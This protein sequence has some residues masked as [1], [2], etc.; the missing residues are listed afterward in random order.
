MARDQVQ[1]TFKVFNEEF[2]KAMSEMREST[3]RLN[4]EFRLQKEQLRLTG[5]ESEK[6]RAEVGY[7]NERY[8]QAQERVK[9]TEQQLAKAKE[10]FGENSKEVK[11]LE[12]Q[13]MNAR[14]E[15]QKFANQL[16]I[17]NKE[18]KIAESRALKYSESLIK[19]GDGLQ[20]AGKKIKDTGKSMTTKITLPIIGLGAAAVKSSIDFESAFAGVRK[21]VDATEEQLKQL[22]TG[23]RNMSKEIPASATAIASVA[24]AAGQLGIETDNILGFSRAMIDLGESTNLSAEEAASALAQ[25]ANI[26]GMSQKDFDRLGSTI[27]ELGNNLATTEADIV[28]MGQRLAGAGAQIGLTEAQIMSFAAALSSVG[29]EAEAGGSAF[30]KV[31]IEMQLATETNSKKLKDFAKVAGMSAKDFKKAFQRDAASAIIAFIKGLSKAEDRGTS[32]IKVLDDMGIKEVRLRDALLR[33]TEASDV[34]TSSIELGSKAWEENTALA[35][36]AAQRYET[37]E[38]RLQIMKNQYIDIGRQLGDK[39]MPVLEKGLDMAQEWVNKLGNLSDAQ[40]E[41]IIKIGLAVAAIGPLLQ[42]TGNAITVVGGFSK[43]IGT[44]SGAIGTMITGA[45]ASTPAIAKLSSVLGALSSPAG[46][47]AA[48]IGLTVGGVAYAMWKSEE[49]TRAAGKAGE[50]FIQSLSTWHDRV[51][52]AKSALEGFNMETII[53]SEKMSELENGIRQ[54]QENIIGI[55]EL[56]AAES[57]AYTE[58]ERKQIEEL[59]GLIAEYTQQKIEA[60]EQQAKVVAAMATQERDITLE[61]A[62]ELIKGAEDARAQLLAIAEVRY[63]EQIAQAIKLYGEQGELDKARYDEMVA[64]AEREYK[65]E[66]ENANKIHGDTLRIIQQKYLDSNTEAKK[67][68]EDVVRINNELARL[69]DEKN[70]KLIDTTNMTRA[71]MQEAARHNFLVE[72]E[73]SNE[74][75]VLL[76]EL[77]DAYRGAE[78][79]NADAWLG[80]A[81]EAELYGG[82]IDTKTKETARGF[83][84]SFQHLPKKSKETMAN[85]MQGMMSEMER[86]EPSLFK[87]ARNIANGILNSLRKAFD[88]R[89]PSRE[90]AKI[91]RQVFEGADKPFA[92]AQKEMSD[93]TKKIADKIMGEMAKVTFEPRFN[94][95]DASMNLTRP[96]L[97]PISQVEAIGMDNIIIKLSD[98]VVPVY[99]E[100]KEIARATAPYMDTELNYIATQRRR[101]R[102]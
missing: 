39:L 78:E 80:M 58:E 13:L 6:L 73:Y 83:I 17:A 74:R 46:L 92:D 7:L 49:A 29:I 75:K 67:Y 10:I 41:N 55:A 93:K 45:E 24:E 26:T 40:M 81:M 51:N 19:I 27:V 43:A 22:E 32:A 48:A 66:I 25:F 50:S 68:L 14:I 100:G 3:T 21:T 11:K 77:A 72:Q 15:E 54:A 35:K 2:K 98:L 86:K 71:E 8:K 9:A 62:Q 59:I 63:Q 76:Q 44:V 12:D 47:A 84:E 101:G 5:S 96:L 4:R 102:R 18:L 53:T 23:I 34:F 20:D 28:S 87:K 97:K 36:E 69:E 89:S 82:K 65:L 91:M 61:R 42:V 88:I 85:T 16:Q 38:S 30:S 60:Y 57:R 33:A 90:M 1:I 31:M 79:N 52:N 95:L 99:L 94:A 70:K 56:A 64:Q 37:T